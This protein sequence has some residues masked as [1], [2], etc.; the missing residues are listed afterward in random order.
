[1]QLTKF[2]DYCLRV[3]MY[4]S[5]RED[6]LA[7]VSEIA[8]AYRVSRNHMMKVAQHLN[9]KGYVQTVRGKNGGIRLARAPEFINLGEAVRDCEEDFDIV[10]C[11]NPVNSDCPL[12]PACALRA[13]L[14]EATKNFLATLDRLTI[15]DLVRGQR[16]AVAGT[17][18]IRINRAA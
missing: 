7:T 3:L 17:K 11:F 6:R 13:S 18:T 9:A 15:A 14:R 8:A 4:L 2:T 5:V 10:E 1:M 12:L 16:F